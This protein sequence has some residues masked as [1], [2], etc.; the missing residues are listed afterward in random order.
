MASRAPLEF[1]GG[2]CDGDTFKPPKRTATPEP[3]Y[4]IGPH[5]PFRNGYYEWD[6][7]RGVYR[8]HPDGRES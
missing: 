6:P 2:P 4:G 7:D 1:V 8:W 5:W 3:L